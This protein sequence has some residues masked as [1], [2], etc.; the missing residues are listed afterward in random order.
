VVLNKWRKYIIYAT[1][2][3]VMAAYQSAKNTDTRQTYYMERPHT[4]LLAKASIVYPEYDCC[5]PHQHWS[6]FKSYTQPKEEITPKY[7]SC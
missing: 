1:Y 2:K 4:R 5:L 7:C 3:S 6:T